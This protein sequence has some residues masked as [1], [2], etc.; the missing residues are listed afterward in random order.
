MNFKTKRVFVKV[1]SFITDLFRICI[2]TIMM[3]AG[4]ELFL[5]PNQLSTGGFSGISTIIYYMLKIPVGTSML[6]LNVPLFLIAYFKVGK[7]FFLKAISGTIFLSIFLNAF[8]RIEPI[9]QDRFLAFLYGS[10]I[11]GIGTAIILKANAS[12]GGTDLLA[13]IIKTYKPHLKTGSLI[14]A[15]DAIIIIANTIFFKDIEVGLYSALAIYILGKVLD[16]FFEGI[17]FTKMLLIISNK[18]EEIADRINN[19]LG[20]GATAI[21]AIGMYKKESRKMLLCVM[22]RNEIREARKIIDETDSSAFLIITNA[23]EVYGKG[24]KES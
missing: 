2:G 23:R 6:L 13:T 15:Y 24:F 9:T 17:N 12:T 14:V 11:V 1:R 18:R 21:E 4:L 3:A 10:V 8:A 5:I 7:R 16:I 20:R 19:E 22:N